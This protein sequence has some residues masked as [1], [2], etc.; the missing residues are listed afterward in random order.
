MTRTQVVNMISS[1]LREVNALHFNNDSNGRNDNRIK[2]LT[3]T[4]IK[5]L[6][7]LKKMKR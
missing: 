6:T 7:A 4:R 3:A 5:L 1:N 2:L